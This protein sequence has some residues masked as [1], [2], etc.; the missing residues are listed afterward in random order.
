MIAA[1]SRPVASVGRWRRRR[2]GGA[3]AVAE[4]A[5][6]QPLVVVLL[7][8]HGEIGQTFASSGMRIAE[9]VLPLRDRTEAMDWIHPQAVCYQLTGV[10]ATGM[11]L[12]VAKHRLAVPGHATGVVIKLDGLIE[13]AGVLLQLLWVTASVEAFKHV[14]VEL[15]DPIL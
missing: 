5:G 4:D 3:M 7:P 9:A 14:V 11:L 2:V 15:T 1:F 13:V 6:N 12:R 8:D 10:A